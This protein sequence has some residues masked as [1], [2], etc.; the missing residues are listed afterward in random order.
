MISFDE[1]IDKVKTLLKE[2]EDDNTIDTLEFLDVLNASIATNEAELEERL[3]ILKAAQEPKIKNAIEDILKQWKPAISQPT[4]EFEQLVVNM[5]ELVDDPNFD[6]L[7]ALDEFDHLLDE[8]NDVVPTNVNLTPKAATPAPKKVLNIGK[9]IIGNMLAKTQNTILVD[10]ANEKTMNGNGGISGAIKQFYKGKGK[11]KDYVADILKFPMIKG[12]RCPN[13]EVKLT[14]THGVDVIHTSAPDLRQKGNCIKGSKSPTAEAEQKLFEAYYNTYR[15]AYIL[16]YGED[17]KA[18]SLSCPIL[19][20]GIY[21]WPPERSAEIAGKA[22]IAFRQKYGNDVKVDFYTHPND[23]VNG[24]TEEKIQKAIE[25]G[26]KSVTFGPVVASDDS[27]NVVTTQQTQQPA[28][29][30]SGT[31]NKPL[32]IPTTTKAQ[33][34]QSTASPAVDPHKN[35]IMKFLDTV[36]SNLRSPYANT[37]AKQDMVNDAN[38]YRAHSDPEIRDKAEKLWPQ[39]VNLAQGLTLP[40]SFGN[41][42]GINVKK[43]YDQ[44]RSVSG[45]DSLRSIVRNASKK[46]VFSKDPVRDDQIARVQK[47]IDEV[48]KASTAL[49]KKERTQQ[50]YYALEN[51]KSGIKQNKTIISPS[52]ALAKI[53]DDLIAKI[54][55]QLISE[56]KKVEISDKQS[57]SN[58]H[59]K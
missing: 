19:G 35:A 31:P 56:F 55:K 37:A 20:S 28:L 39:V 16:N 41:F 47:L 4:T 21:Q 59:K 30:A 54:P 44:E 36:T 18:R 24:L 34:V 46:V 48:N 32:P 27:S 50:L 42:S 12:K 29:T 58:K 22:L 5:Q 45:A 23:L 13:G 17:K 52:S 9:V 38:K 49:D 2:I 40:V 15:M 10:A 8:N 6:I 53:C 26:F 33:P 3:E 51:L 14:R 25:K 1:V 43:L 57:V 7:D 11:L